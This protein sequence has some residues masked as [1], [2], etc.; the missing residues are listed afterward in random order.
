MVV[1]D[2]GL[3]HFVKLGLEVSASPF[4][5]RLAEVSIA[6]DVGNHHSGKSA[7]HAAHSTPL[8]RSARGRAAV[9]F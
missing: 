8:T 5:V 3:E 9:S 2:L 4:L 6:S 1:R 7:L